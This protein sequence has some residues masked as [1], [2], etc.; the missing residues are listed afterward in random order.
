MRAVDTDP[1]VPTPERGLGLGQ[2]RLRGLECENVRSRTRCGTIAEGTIVGLCMAAH[3]VVPLMRGHGHGHCHV[4]ARGAY[5]DLERAPSGRHES[6]RHIG[7]QQQ[8][9]QQDAAQERS[10]PG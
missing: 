7:T 1:K 3:G 8:H 2:Y 10:L 9:G 5:L 6:R 4:H